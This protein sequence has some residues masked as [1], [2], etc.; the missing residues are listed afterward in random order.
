MR[1]VPQSITKVPPFRMIGNIYF[2]GTV[3]ASSHLIDTGDGLI[4]IDTGYRENA[5]TVVESI[6]ELGYDVKDIK[7]ILHS[8]G[9]YDHTDATATLLT[10]A[11]NAKTYLSFRDLRYIKDF[12]PDFDIQDGT[13]V[14]L[15]NTK[16]ECWFTPGHTEGS[17]SFFLDVEEDG[18]TYKAAMF[19][20]SG[21]NQLKK[22]FMNNWQVSYLCRGLFFDSVERLLKRKVD[23]MIGNHSWQN[24]TLEKRDRMKEATL[25]PFIDPLEWETYLTKLYNAL[26]RVI[27]TES[28]TKFINYAHRGAQAYSPENTMQAFLVGVGMGANGIET[29]IQRTKDGKLVLFHDTTLERILGQSG[30][31]QDYTYTELSCFCLDRGESFVKIPML[32]RFLTEFSGKNISFAL[33]L[34]VDDIEKEVL[35]LLYEYDVDKRTIITSFSLD[36]LRKVKSLDS[37]MHVG[38]LTKTVDDALIQTLLEIGVDELCPHASIVTAEAV[39][40]WH[41]LGFNVRAFGVSNVEVMKSLYDIGVDGMTVDFPD[42]LAEYIEEKN[43]AVS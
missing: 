18:K 28:R 26:W 43:P 2:V 39:E 33:E 1:K 25:N 41:R 35:D 30:R 40:K 14:E 6:T 29:D 27:R 7:I 17:V 38:Y 22:D 24:H 32:E 15:G 19:G 37:Y 16:I 5:E 21:V 9:H 10:V 34:K 31:I 23:V 3:E 8:H 11:P 4:L 12:T 36:R 20:G 13:V 42:R